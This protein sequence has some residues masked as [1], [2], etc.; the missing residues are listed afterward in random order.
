MYKNFSLNTIGSDPTIAS[1]C[2]FLHFLFLQTHVSHMHSEYSAHVRYVLGNV[3]PRIP[4]RPHLYTGGSH[5]H[6]YMNS[7]VPHYTWDILPYTSRR[8]FALK[9]EAPF[10]QELLWK[11]VVFSGCR[12]KS[13]FISLYLSHM[14]S[15]LLHSTHLPPCHEHAHSPLACWKHERAF[16]L[17]AAANRRKLM[18]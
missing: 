8:I 7:W 9:S 5:V 13:D 15:R 11:S 10:Y 12:K 17:K 4:V 18:V 1:L 3:L 16:T 6:P 2:H 14:D